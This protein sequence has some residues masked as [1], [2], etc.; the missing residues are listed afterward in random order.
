MKNIL[1]KTLIMNF[2]GKGYVEYKDVTTLNKIYFTLCYKQF[3]R[4]VSTM[5]VYYLLINHFTCLIGNQHE[6]RTNKQSDRLIYRIK[7]NYHILVDNIAKI[8]PCDKSLD[9]V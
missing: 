7:A 9:F 1:F 4:H 8:L 2:D 5:T 3:N 6:P